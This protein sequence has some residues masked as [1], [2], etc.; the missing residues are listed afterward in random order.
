MFPINFIQ[1]EASQFYEVLT[2]SNSTNGNIHPESS[3][4][5]LLIYCLFCGTRAAA[6]EPAR[7]NIVG[8]CGRRH[9]LC[10]QVFG[11]SVQSDHLVHPN[12]IQRF[13]LILH[14]DPPTS[15]LI[16]LLM[17]SKIS[18]K[19]PHCFLLFCN[20]SFPVAPCTQ[21]PPVAVHDSCCLCF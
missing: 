13:P 3:Y 9:I 21:S 7:T 19:T 14:L 18:E 17:A 8:Q 16:S 15:T 5:S 1:I 10:N 11:A 4:M 6:A 20:Q 12:Q 2:R